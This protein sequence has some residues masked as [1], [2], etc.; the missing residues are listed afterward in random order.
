MLQQ[1]FG[2]MDVRVTTLHKHALKTVNTTV[3]PI[4]FSV[5]SLFCG[6]CANMFYVHCLKKTLSN[7]YM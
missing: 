7:Q 2:K 1:D 3:K 4:D 6:H 5:Q